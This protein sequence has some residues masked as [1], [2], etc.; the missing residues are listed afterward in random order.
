MPKISSRQNLLPRSAPAVRETLSL[1]LFDRPDDW[2]PAMTVGERAHLRLVVEVEK[3]GLSAYSVENFLDWDFDLDAWARN[4]SVGSCEPL[5]RM[6]QKGDPNLELARCVLLMRGNKLCRDPV[7][8][9]DDGGERFHVY[10]RRVASMDPKTRCEQEIWSMSPSPSS[11]A[12]GASSDSPAQDWE[13]RTGRSGYELT[14]GIQKIWG[15]RKIRPS[16]LP[17]LPSPGLEH[18]PNLGDERACTDLF[19]TLRKIRSSLFFLGPGSDFDRS[20]AQIRGLYS[21]DP[22]YTYLFELDIRFIAG[23]FFDEMDGLGLFYPLIYGERRPDLGGPFSSEHAPDLSKPI[24]TLE[25]ELRQAATDPELVFVARRLPEWAVLHFWPDAFWSRE[26]EAFMREA[27]THASDSPCG[28]S[29]GE[30]QRFRLRDV[31]CPLCRSRPGFFRAMAE[32]EIRL[33][34][35]DSFK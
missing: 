16:D 25:Q 15:T 8:Q 2:S 18:K 31:S 23:F 10:L 9:I 14:N 5:F 11:R 21:G 28:F 29:I 20:A 35:D 32:Q 34:R 26:H 30:A 13:D 3:T 33:A 4:G 1:E 17:P 12:M 22:A 7:F 6:L 19:A 27:I 24:E